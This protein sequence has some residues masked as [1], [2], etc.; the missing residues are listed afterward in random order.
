ML[1]CIGGLWDALERFGAI[2]NFVAFEALGGFWA[3]GSFDFLE[4]LGHLGILEHLGA[5]ENGTKYTL[6]H[7][8]IFYIFSV[9]I[10]ARKRTNIC[11]NQLAA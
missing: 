2:R 7:F 3:F 5:L 6:C 9:V 10:L 4:A 11:K 1:G 8:T